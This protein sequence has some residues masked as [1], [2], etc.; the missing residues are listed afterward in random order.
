MSKAVIQKPAPEF[1][2]DAVLPGGQ[3]GSVSLSQFKGAA[4]PCPPA[5]QPPEAAHRGNPV[6]ARAPDVPEG[7]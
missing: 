4:P 6:R 7:A 1:T 3:F 2:A 5:P